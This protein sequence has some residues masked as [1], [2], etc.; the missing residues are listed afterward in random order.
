MKWTMTFSL[1]LQENDPYF[2]NHKVFPGLIGLRMNPFYII[3]IKSALCMK[4][5]KRLNEAPYDLI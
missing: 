1:V 4:K 2:L 3:S 5:K